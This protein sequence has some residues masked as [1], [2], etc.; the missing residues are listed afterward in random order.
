MDDIIEI[1]LTEDGKNVEINISDHGPGIRDNLK[2][3]LFDRIRSG[4]AMVQ[5]FG[6]IIGKRTCGPL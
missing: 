1:I 4:K 5:G 6:S 2:P 3:I